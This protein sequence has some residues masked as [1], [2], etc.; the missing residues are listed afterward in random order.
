M[1]TSIT[2]INS[3]LSLKYICITLYTQVMTKLLLN[4]QV[5]S[6]DVKALVY[7]EHSHMRSNKKGLL[8]IHILLYCNKLKENWMYLLLYKKRV[9]IYY[10]LYSNLRFCLDYIWTTFHYMKNGL[11]WKLVLG[12]MQWLVIDL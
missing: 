2:K 8:S 9:V 7:R 4:E 11:C 5:Q 12:S 3:P 6:R 10:T 1:Q